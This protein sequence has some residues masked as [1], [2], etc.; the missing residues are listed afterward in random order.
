M[1]DAITPAVV[2]ADQTVSE[3]LNAQIAARLIQQ[4][5]LDASMLSLEEVID[6]L[7]AATF[8]QTPANGYEAE[9]NR[10]VERVV[11]DNLMRLAA[12]APMSQARAVATLSLEELDDRMQ[13]ASGMQTADVAHYNLL[14]RD[15]ERFMSRPA[16]TYSQPGTPGAPPGAPI[17]D[18]GLDYLGPWGGLG[19]PLGSSPYM[20]GLEPYCSQDELWFR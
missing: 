13:T 12:T 1:F 8:G 15:I 7:L 18:S 19:A 4:H 9:I 2:A 16:E 10:A 6:R 3:I 20:L 5:A 17:G 14:S 11:V